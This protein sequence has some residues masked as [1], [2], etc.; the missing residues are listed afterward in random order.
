MIKN[1]IFLGA[2]GVGKGTM[3]SL[4]SGEKGLV[5]IS[6]GEI[7][8]K[9]IREQTELGKQVTS[10]LDSGQYVSDEITNA[11]VKKA[12]STKECKTKGFILDGYPRTIVQANFLDSLGVDVKAVLLDASDDTIISRL[13]GRNSGRA[14]DNPEVIK[15]RLKVYNESTAPLI[16]Y[17]KEKGLLIVINAEDTIEENFKVVKKELFNDTY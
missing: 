3:A 1:Y 6:T 16:D 13:N 12:I 10:L 5:H 14:D 11:I 2:P 15:T 4:L 9:E 7:F 8:R 17:Y